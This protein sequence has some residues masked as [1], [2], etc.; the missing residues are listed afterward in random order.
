MLLSRQ[1]GR[2]VLTSDGAR[3]GR[4]VDL[5]VLLGA[6]HPVVHRVGIG[7]RRR[8]DYLVPWSLVGGVDGDTLRLSTDR[9]GL[10][11][12]AVDDQPALEEHELLMCRDVLDPQVVDLAG[13]RLS[14]VSDVVVARGPDGRVEVVAVDVGVGSLLRRMGLGRLADHLEPV[15]VD[16]RD[17][18][19]TSNR[20]HVVQLATSS[21][22]LHRLT[23]EELAEVLA[24]LSTTDAT[25]VIR[26]VGPARSA[27]ALRASHP[28]L[29]RRLLH[30]LPPE[31]AQHVI[32]AA[33][34]SNGDSLL[35]AHRSP[36]APRRRLRTAGW[37]VHRPPRGTAGRT[38][39][40]RRDGGTSR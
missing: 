22:G 36:T 15:V 23:P 10:A 39:V 29:R 19:L 35:Q 21:T 11:R 4:L 34:G 16:W 32:E 25:D 3:A 13:R 31:E 7:S 17:L 27:R 14:R 9:A 20:G 37:R 5:S 38:A 12:Y 26:T 18:H 30:S 24:R 8:V 6:A 28:V 2:L 1:T 40:R 33:S